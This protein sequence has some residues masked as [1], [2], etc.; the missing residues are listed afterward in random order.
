MEVRILLG[1]NARHVPAWMY[2]QDQGKGV[3]S[4]VGA[5]R[6]P[7]LAAH[8]LRYGSRRTHQFLVGELV[9]RPHMLLA[10]DALRGTGLSNLVLGHDVAAM[11]RQG[12]AIIG[13]PTPYCG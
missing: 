11:L 9:V 5:S 7:D 12:E 8:P 10:T 6:V 3:V 4:F 13:D 1:D 2:V